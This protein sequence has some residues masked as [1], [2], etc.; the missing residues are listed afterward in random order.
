M[1]M[2]TTSV[3]VYP[4]RAISCGD[5]SHTFILAQWEKQQTLIGWFVSERTRDRLGAVIYGPMGEELVDKFIAERE[6]D[7]QNAGK[8]FGKGQRRQ[9]A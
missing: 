2:R 1:T 8:T 5:K 6:K 3:R 4:D 9:I 7:L